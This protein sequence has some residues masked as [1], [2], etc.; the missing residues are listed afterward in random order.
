MMMIRSSSCYH[1]HH[2]HHHQIEGSRIIIKIIKTVMKGILRE[3]TSRVPA[4]SE[5]TQTCQRGSVNDD[6]DN[7]DDIDDDKNEDEVVDE[8]GQNQC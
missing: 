1:F 3:Q 6:D 5:L 8:E 2:H 4:T 7:D